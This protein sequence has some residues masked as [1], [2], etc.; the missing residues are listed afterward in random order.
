MQ[1]DVGC[2]NDIGPVP[3]VR[4]LQLG[5]AVATADVPAHTPECVIAGTRSGGRPEHVPLLADPG[6]EKGA[7]QGLD[8]GNHDWLVDLPALAV[9]GRDVQ[10][11]DGW[12]RVGSRVVDIAYGA[13]KRPGHVAA[14]VE[15]EHPAA[16]LDHPA[17]IEC[18]SQLATA[19]DERKTRADEDFVLDG[20]MIPK[21]ATA[22]AVGP[23]DPR[24]QLCRAL[25]GT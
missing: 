15:T 5:G 19:A 1:C 9:G 16:A 11:R 23:D 6:I 22:V 7:V 25:R 21:L 2:A 8:P 3:N 24:G 14:S 18:I 12:R 13:L 17:C 4:Q 20:H 10:E